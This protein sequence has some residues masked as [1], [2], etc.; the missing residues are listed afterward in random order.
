MDS[1]I[2]ITPC[3][4]GHGHDATSESLRTVTTLVDEDNFLNSDGSVLAFTDDSRQV[5]ASSSSS[6]SSAKE[7]NLNTNLSSLIS[8]TSEAKTN[9]LNDEQA[10]V[11]P[12]ET[13]ENDCGCCSIKFKSSRNLANINLF[14]FFMCLIVML[15]NALTVGYRNSVITTIEKRFEISSSMSGVLG[16]ALEVGSLL[17]TLYISYFCA[18]SHIPRCIALSSLCCA[19]GALIYALPHFISNSYTIGNRV[20]NKT[21]SDIMCHLN[22]NVN[23]LNQNFA[24]SKLLSDC[25]GKST[26]LFLFALL[27]IANVL[28]GSSSA[29]LYTLGTTYIDNH[30]KKENSSIYLAFMYSMLAFGPVIGYLLGAFTLGYYVDILSYNLKLSRDDSGWIGAWW[31][32]FLLL[33]VLIFITS[34]PFFC[35]PKNLK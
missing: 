28:I 30:V 26:S 12:L 32:G 22:E 15:T 23:E 27:I 2:I 24:F 35:F 31:I 3:L 8:H 11:K 25:M 16:G 7:L 5:S 14:V 4:N 21:T 29:P 34:F 19:L 17:A 10:Q 13:N 1:N 20:M 18:N 9:F 6:V 33:A